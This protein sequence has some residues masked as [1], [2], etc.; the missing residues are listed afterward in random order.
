MFG[1]NAYKFLE[2]AIIY[3]TKIDYTT[4]KAFVLVWPLPSKGKS[5]KTYV[6]YLSTALQATEHKGRWYFFIVTK[7]F[8]AY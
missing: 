8:F 3:I 1:F 4:Q 7:S 2:Y 6:L 5:Y